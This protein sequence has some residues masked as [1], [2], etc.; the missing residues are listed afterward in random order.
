MKIAIEVVK[1]Y[2]DGLLLS[3]IYCDVYKCLDFTN[4]S[5]PKI[6]LLASTF[7]KIVAPL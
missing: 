4:I 6:T 7:T 3:N 1:Y 2:M 5:D